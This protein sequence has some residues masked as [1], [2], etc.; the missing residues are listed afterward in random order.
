MR[1]SLVCMSREALAPTEEDTLRAEF[2]CAS[3]L[4]ATTD[5]SAI[6]RRIRSAESARKFFDREVAWAPERDFELCL[7]LDRFD[8][9][10]E[11]ERL[12]RSVCRLRKVEI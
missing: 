8:F 2:I 10:L 9:V 4:G 1:V 5:F 7:S 12:D 11:A 6:S 3:L